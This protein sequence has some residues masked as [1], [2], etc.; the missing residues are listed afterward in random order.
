[1][2]RLHVSAGSIITDDKD[3]LLLVQEGKEHIK[4]RWD[5]PG[6]SL[7]PG[8]NIKECAIREA[9]EEVNLDIK[10]ENLIGIYTEE[11]MR[12]GD[13]VIF[14]T[15]HAKPESGEVQIPKEG[16]E[17]LDAEFFSIE[18]AMN[19]EL[20]KENRYTVLEDFREGQHLPL[21]TLKDVR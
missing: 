2:N 6:G 14:C 19:K 4:G 20:R 7:E 21:E 10:L 3:R 18:E 5:F 12:T 17:I 13:T 11:S 9:K 8:E 15:F 1:M 16:D